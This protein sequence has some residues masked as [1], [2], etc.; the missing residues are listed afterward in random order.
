MM[1]QAQLMAE[2]RAALGNRQDS[3][4]TD[5]RVVN[6][7]NL[8]QQRISRFYPFPE[9]RAD[10]F[11]TG[12]VTANPII[13]KWLVLPPSVRV[14]HSFVL[15][16][17]A[18]SRKLSE[19]PWRR[20]DYNVPLPEFIAPDWPSYYTRFDLNVLML[21][22]VPLKA[23]QFFMRA[24]MLPTPFTNVNPTLSSQLSDFVDKDDI[25]IDLATSRFWKSLGR[26]SLAKFME[27]DALVRLVEARASAE[28]HPDMDYSPDDMGTGGAIPNGEYW[29]SPFVMA[30]E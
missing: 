12:V 15:Q 4:I 3:Q 27:E 22:P 8:A 10:W 14:I 9:L 5:A 21:F 7:I 23:F 28:E 11:A 1:T 13:D 17:E 19:K 18:N 25:I 20:F 16:D 26:P 2:V 6:N 24:T 30:V 29:A